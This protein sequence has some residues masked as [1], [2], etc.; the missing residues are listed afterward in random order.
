MIKFTII[1]TKHNGIIGVLVNIIIIQ[2]LNFRKIAHF[3]GG[4]SVSL[5]R[6]FKTRHIMTLLDQI[7]RLVD[8]NNLFELFWEKHR[9]ID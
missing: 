7:F 8:K 1:E 5:E 9:D 4:A 6:K 3:L 2:E